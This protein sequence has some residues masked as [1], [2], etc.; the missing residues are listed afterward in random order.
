MGGTTSRV[1]PGTGD[2]AI[3]APALHHAM[4]ATAH[5]FTVF[6]VL[7]PSRPIV[8]QALVVPAVRSA[9]SL[10]GAPTCKHVRAS[11]R[12][13]SPSAA[14]NALRVAV[15]VTGFGGTQRMLG[16]FTNAEAGVPQGTS[17]RATVSSLNPSTLYLP[18]GAPHPPQGVQAGSL[19]APRLPQAT[20]IDARTPRGPR[21][22]VL[23][24]FPC[25]SNVVAGAWL[26]AGMYLRSVRR[27]HPWICAPQVGRTPPNRSSH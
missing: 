7:G 20:Q 24:D 2:T 5:T 9:L 23:A 19:N 10:A 4:G 13:V 22:S 25:S 11:S 8:P 17:T 14:D 26:I 12:A 21:C 6:P 1:E 3:P 16:E 27:T 18:L 15:P